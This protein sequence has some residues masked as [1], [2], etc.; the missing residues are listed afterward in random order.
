MLKIL[1]D[2][3]IQSDVDVTIGTAFDYNHDGLWEDLIND[4]KYNNLS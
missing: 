4:T 1:Q 2:Y 3:A